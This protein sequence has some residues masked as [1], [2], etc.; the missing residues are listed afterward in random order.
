MQFFFRLLKTEHLIATF[1]SKQIHSLTRRLEEKSNIHLYILV[2]VHNYKACNRRNEKP[3][4]I[5]S[6]HTVLSVFISRQRK[7][8]KRR[9]KKLSSKYRQNNRKTGFLV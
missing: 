8:T 5:L 4:T 3:T 1:V 6:S 9:A 7:S 2:L